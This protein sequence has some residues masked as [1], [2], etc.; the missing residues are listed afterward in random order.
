MADEK[1]KEQYVVM[2]VMTRNALVD[3]L[4]AH[5]PCA[6]AGV[7]SRAV[8]TLQNLPVMEV[9][10]V[11]SDTDSPQPRVSELQ[12][13]KTRRKRKGKTLPPV[14]TIRTG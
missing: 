3:L 14:K 9:K 7:I 12:K 8:L 6:Y 2:P 13:V 1:P 11:W 4:Q 5:I 10:D